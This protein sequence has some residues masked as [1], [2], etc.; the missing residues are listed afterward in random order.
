[1]IRRSGSL[2]IGAD[3][4]HYTGDVFLNLS[5]IVALVLATRFNVTWA[6]SIFGIGIALFLL[7]NAAHI[8]SRAVESLMD[9][10][11]PEVDRRKIIEVAKHHP[12]VRNVH[13]LRTRSSGLQQFIQMHIVLDKELT[14]LDA[15]RISDEV[16]AAVQADYP[17]A[18]IIIHQDPEGVAEFHP[19]VGAAL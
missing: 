10:E 8:A 1:V 14:L 11:L 15:H 5:V 9:R 13:E 17:N 4:L 6:D 7:I 2:A 12:R 3:N 18:D 19:P 16:E